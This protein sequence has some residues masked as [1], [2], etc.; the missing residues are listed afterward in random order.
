MSNWID[1]EGRKLTEELAKKQH[2]EN[3]VRMSNY[4]ASLLHQIQMDAEDIGE[5]PHWKPLIGSPLTIKQEGGGL[6]IIRETFPAMIIEVMSNGDSVAVESVVFRVPGKPE[7]RKKEILPVA[8]S[9]ENVYLTNG[10]SIYVI[11]EQASKYI[12]SRLLEFLKENALK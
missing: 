4:W 10:E 12:L 5:S 6:K 2:R 8:S 9:G 3:V 1:E 11:P 7:N